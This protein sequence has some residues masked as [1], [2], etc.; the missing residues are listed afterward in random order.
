[1]L[2]PLINLLGCRNDELCVNK[3]PDS[4]SGVFASRPNPLGKNSELGLPVLPDTALV[5]ELPKLGRGEGLSL[6]A[7]LPNPIATLEL[8]CLGWGYVGD[9]IPRPANPLA[10]PDEAVGGGPRD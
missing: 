1:M 8:T 9:E 2:K 6:T 7:P 3:G 4:P 5:P 10:A